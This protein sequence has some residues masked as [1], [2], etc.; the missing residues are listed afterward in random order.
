MKRLYDAEIAHVDYQLGRLL[1]AAESKAGAGGLWVFVMSDHGESFGEHG[2]YFWRDLYEPTMRV[3]LIIRMPN[4][5]TGTVLDATVGLVDIAPTILEILDL[6][7][8]KQLDGRSLLPLLRNE[9][10]E[11][12]RAQVSLIV[13]TRSHPYA[14]NNVAT[15]S[16]GVKPILS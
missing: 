14:R 3:P 5:A 15:R 1:K 7:S 10:T 8:D 2:I 4:D 9:G 16:A 11:T 13:P 12:Q 6:K